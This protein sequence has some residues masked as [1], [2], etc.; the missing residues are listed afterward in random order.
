ML[1]TYAPKNARLDE[2]SIKVEGNR[3]TA[4]SRIV[5]T[6]ISIWN[7]SLVILQ[8]S[9]NEGFLYRLVSLKHSWSSHKGKSSSGQRRTATKTQ[10]SY[11]I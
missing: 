8:F 4:K 1:P 7:G 10:D 3:S 9:C 5:R 6:E 11:S 2:W